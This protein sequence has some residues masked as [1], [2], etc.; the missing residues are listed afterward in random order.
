MAASLPYARRESTTKCP[1]LSELSSTDRLRN[2]ADT[3]A[4]RGASRF[5]ASSPFR[6]FSV[7]TSVPSLSASLRRAAAS[8][9]DACAVAFAA[10]RAASAGT[11]A[12]VKSATSAASADPSPSATERGTAGSAFLSGV[13]GD[14]SSSP[15]AANRHR[16]N[17]CGGGAPAPTAI[18]AAFSFFRSL[19]RAT[20]RAH[21][22]VAATSGFF[23]YAVFFPTPEAMSSGGAHF[24]AFCARSHSAPTLFVPLP[25][26]GRPLPTS[27]GVGRTRP[28][29]DTSSSFPKEAA[30][31]AA[32]AFGPFHGLMSLG[33]LVCACAGRRVVADLPMRAAWR[34]SNLRSSAGGGASANGVESPRGGVAHDEKR[35]WRRGACR[36]H[37]SSS[38]KTSEA[39]VIEFLAALQSRPRE[40]RA[41]R[42]GARGGDDVRDAPVLGHDTR[43]GTFRD[44]R[45][46]RPLRIPLD[47]RP[48]ASRVSRNGDPRLLEALP[49]ETDHR[50][51]SPSPARGCLPSFRRPRSSSRSVLVPARRTSPRRTRGAW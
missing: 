33:A 47:R 24:C 6:R 8:A 30:S 40:H 14:A 31:A 13:P 35:A 19:S 20:A 27:P 29:P 11:P 23:W 37:A 22:S 2:T 51:S 4:K 28:P 36:F 38:W 50:A 48:R 10:S 17:A 45:P 5:A 12:R 18:A 7:R 9:L 49:S 15:V 46:S 26:M 44:A 41:S 32:A 34:D 39:V 42:R 1:P 3:R 25:A 43:G 21:S 16:S